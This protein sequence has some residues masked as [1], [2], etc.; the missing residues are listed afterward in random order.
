MVQQYVRLGASPRAAQAMV[1]A[2]KC[3]ALRQGRSA[4]SIE[5]IAESALASLRHRLIMN[6][7]SSAEGVTPDAVIANITQTLPVEGS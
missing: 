7:E 3:R 2:G 4:V 6:F 1:L 5:D